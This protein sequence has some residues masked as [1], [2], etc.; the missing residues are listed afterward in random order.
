M[1][2]IASR[3]ACLNWLIWFSA[4]A[5]TFQ[6]ATHTSS[7]SVLGP[8]SELGIDSIAWSMAVPYR[9]S[10]TAVMN[11]ILAHSS[12]PMSKGTPESLLGNFVSDLVFVR[13]TADCDRTRKRPPDLCLLNIGG[14]RSSLPAGDILLRHVYELM[15]FDNE[16]VIVE[17]AG[18]D[19]EQLFHYIW[20]RKGCPVSNLKLV[21]EDSTWKEVT[22]G[23]LPFDPQRTYRV[24]TS[25]YLA[26]GGDNMSFFEHPVSYETTGLRIRDAIIDHVR[27]AGLSGQPIHAELD[28]RIRIR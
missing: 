4:C 14:L 12:Q 27:K 19:M 8:V 23:G 2:I 20:E 18:A 11:G 16:I 15:P 5:A 22:I 3:F 17:L 9:D 24:L 1:R 13:G 25:D 26:R 7:V 28:G 10:V 6:P 21:L